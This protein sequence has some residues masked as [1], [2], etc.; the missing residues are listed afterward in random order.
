MDMIDR[1]EPF[2]RTMG[3]RQMMD[4]LL[5]DTFILPRKAGNDGAAVAANDEAA[6]KDVGFGGSRLPCP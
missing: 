1:Y 2:G 3:L 6:G 5:E 4:R